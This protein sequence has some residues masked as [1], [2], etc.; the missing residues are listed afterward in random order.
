MAQ[1]Q[2]E[3]DFLT[4]SFS[5][6]EDQPMDMLLG[7]YTINSVPD[8]EYLSS[9]IWCS[10]SFDLFVSTPFESLACRSATSSS[11]KEVLYG[12]VHNQ[13]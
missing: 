13:L 9:Y 11:L 8:T 7:R 6:L 10:K 12:I 5:I 2:I 3:K 1:I 4:S